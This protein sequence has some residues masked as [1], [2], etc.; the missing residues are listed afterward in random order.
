MPRHQIKRYTNVPKAMLRRSPCD[1]GNADSYAR[2]YCCPLFVF[3]AG[4]KRR[5]MTNRF[6]VEGPGSIFCC[7]TL[8]GAFVRG[9]ANRQERA[10]LRIRLHEG[11]GRFTTSEPI[12]SGCLRFD[13]GQEILLAPVRIIDLT[14][15]IF[16]FS[17]TAAERTLPGATPHLNKTKPTDI[18]PLRSGR[19]SVMNPRFPFGLVEDSCGRVDSEFHKVYPSRSSASLDQGCSR[20]RSALRL[21][22]LLGVQKFLLNDGKRDRGSFANYRDVLYRTLRLRHLCHVGTVHGH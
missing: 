9:W 6:N 2:R 1:C 3:T 17:R 18:S 8:T 5:V 21:L 4:V 15:T 12:A 14:L 13:V 22:C 20:I 11:V 7:E 19:S 10:I 16:L